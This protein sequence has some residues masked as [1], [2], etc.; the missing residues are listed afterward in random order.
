MR[1][2]QTWTIGGIRHH[3]ALG[4]LFA[5]PVEAIVNSEQTDFILSRSP[6]SISGQLNRRYGALVADDLARQTGGRVKG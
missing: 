3:L 1:K 4:D 5:A 6:D 2:V